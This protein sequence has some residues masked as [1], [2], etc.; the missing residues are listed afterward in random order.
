M[1]MLPILMLTFSLMGLWPQEIDNDPCKQLYIV[2]DGY[3]S[4]V[5]KTQAPYCS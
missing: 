2:R 3:S 4:G 1:V 5:G